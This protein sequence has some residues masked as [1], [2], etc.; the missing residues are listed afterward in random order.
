MEVDET[1][2]DGPGTLVWIKPTWKR[3]EF[4]VTYLQDLYLFDKAL[5]SSASL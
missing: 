4:E 1:I 5:I 2:M 3:L